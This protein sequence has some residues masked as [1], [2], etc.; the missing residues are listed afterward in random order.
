[1][2]H[3][4]MLGRFRNNLDIGLKLLPV[5][6]LFLLAACGSRNTAPENSKATFSS[7]TAGVTADGSTG[8]ETDRGVS[9]SVITGVDL[10]ETLKQRSGRGTG[11]N[12]VRIY[13]FRRAE[14]V[15]DI[16]GPGIRSGRL[17]MT[18]DENGHF[19]SKRS[20]K[21]DESGREITNWT[22]KR[23]MDLW[24]LDP[25]TKEAVLAVLGSRMPAGFDFQSMIMEFGTREA[26]VAKLA[27]DKIE[28]L[29]DE[30]VK[31]FEC[32][33]FQQDLGP[34]S[35]IRWVNQG[36]ELRMAVVF[37]GKEP[38]IT[39]ELVSADFD[40]VIPDNLFE[41]PEDYSVLTTMDFKSN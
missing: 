24:H 17:T 12:L 14:F 8:M 31:G 16:S 19:E 2:I 39:R 11:E 13:P 6:F 20:E 1:M 40:P 18:V 32:M 4:W 25:V 37:P 26:A 36:V 7:A 9:N 21:V 23:G 28:L 38:Q 41:I 5:V 29:P 35:M 27:E 34:Y 10:D 30:T 3:H 22:I 33:V 15:F